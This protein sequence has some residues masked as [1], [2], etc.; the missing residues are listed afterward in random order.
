MLQ[1][2]QA[3]I[4]D[5]ETTELFKM[6]GRI[7]NYIENNVRL[8]RQGLK[9]TIKQLDERFQKQVKDSRLAN[10][11]LQLKNEQ[12]FSDLKTARFISTEYQNAS[13][14]KQRDLYSIQ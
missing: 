14:E 5:I 13:E 4:D 8:N 3:I 6:K 1:E 2:E 12:L 9:N 10:V 11:E 7:K